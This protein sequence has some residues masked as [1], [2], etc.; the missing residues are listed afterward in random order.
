M[1][2][3][4]PGQRGTALIIVML[5]SAAMAGFAMLIIQRVHSEKRSVENYRA[6]KQAEDAAEA[7]LEYA[8]D[9]LWDRYVSLLGSATPSM[10]AYADY[11]KKTLGQGTT[12]LLDKPLLLAADAEIASIA[13]NMTTTAEGIQL[14]VTSTGRSLGRDRRIVQSLTIGGRTFQGLDY[15][16]LTKNLECVMCHTKID[17]VHRL[18]NNDSGDF[19]SFDRV[20][21]GVLES[22]TLEREKGQARIAGSIHS[23]GDAFTAKEGGD[24][25]PYKGEGLKATM[26]YGFGVDGK[27]LEDKKGK[28]SDTP[29]SQGGVDEHGLP[30][31][32]ENLYLGYPESET[33]MTDG[34]LPSEIPPAVPDSNNN[35]QVDDDEWKQHVSSVGTGVLDDGIAYGVP[36]GNQYAQKGLPENSNAALKELASSGYYDGNLVLVGTEEQPINLKGEVFVN[37]DV[38]ITGYVKGT[39]KITARRNIYFAG[40]TLMADGDSYGQAKDG[41]QNLVGYAAGGSILLGDFLTTT[42]YSENDVSS[43]KVVAVDFQ[44]IKGSKSELS[45]LD[46]RTLDQSP[47]LDKGDSPSHTTQ[48]MMRFNMR[49]AEKA[50]ADPAYTPRY[51]QLREGE[52]VYALTDDSVHGSYRYN[53][54]LMR[55]LT[56]EELKTATLMDM[57]PAGGWIPESTLKQIWYQDELS[58]KSEKKKDRGFEL[59]GMLYTNNALIGLAHSQSWH[60]SNKNGRMTIR[61]A[62]TAGDLGLHASGNGMKEFGNNPGLELF[63]DARVQALSGA[64][65]EDGLTLTRGIQQLAYDAV[66]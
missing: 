40:D 51:Y 6:M 39:G 36:H 56:P 4:S 64:A 47:A 29:L 22:M 52:R 26:G 48:M 66:K 28:V 37:G 62:V 24:K 1:P 7:G 41:T 34:Y 16:L 49:E 5:F 57:A 31:P 21:I 58:R 11:L 42:A 50:K 19:G 54:K 9:V 30:L 8:T 35:R 65:E 17:N 43:G 20:K 12:E 32:M 44:Q 14:L 27:I 18:T 46:D 33:D 15:A 45:Y 25:L 23:R 2:R 63:Y 38:M 10:D 53:S 60:R 61:G 3:R 55:E 59:D 13:V